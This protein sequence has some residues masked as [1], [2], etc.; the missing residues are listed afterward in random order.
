MDLFTCTHRAILVDVP[1]QIWEAIT[2]DGVS[3]TPLWL[4][5]V[6][7]NKPIFYFKNYARCYFHYLSP[8]FISEALSPYAAI[9]IFSVLYLLW[10]KGG[11]PWKLTK[12]ILIL[13]PLIFLF[14]LQNKL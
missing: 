13:Y 8:L 5:R 12:W 11:K 1:Y 3:R 2:T 7:H 10:K 6:L 4:T 14:E 9:A